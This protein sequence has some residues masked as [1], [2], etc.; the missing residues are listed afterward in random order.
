MW[1][2]PGGWPCSAPHM[3]FYIRFAHQ[4]A[5][6]WDECFS[7]LLK[8]KYQ[9]FIATRRNNDCLRDPLA[10]MSPSKQIYKQSFSTTVLKDAKDDAASSLQKAFQAAL[11]AFP[12]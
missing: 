10:R 3:V 6:Q 9:L 4:F 8:R 5:S 12:A 11:P 2:P 1:N 7:S